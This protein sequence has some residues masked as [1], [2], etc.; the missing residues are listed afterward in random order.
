[1]LEC[2][3]FIMCVASSRGIKQQ[4]NG[5]VQFLFMQHEG[6]FLPQNDVS[7]QAKVGC[8]LGHAC[9]QGMVAEQ[10][11]DE[12]CLD[13]PRH[14]AVTRTPTA[15]LA[16]CTFESDYGMPLKCVCLPK[17]SG[18]PACNCV[19]SCEAER[20]ISSTPDRAYIGVAWYADAQWTAMRNC[21][22]GFTAL[23]SKYLLSVSLAEYK[24]TAYVVS[25]T[26]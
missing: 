20:E 17:R 26:S 1:M 24:R 4:E 8:G 3:H 10:R 6:K 16:G 2:S 12:P 18:T 5:H 21:G 25:G 13:Q 11:G 7:V 19:E 9:W 14:H 23:A 15:C 22:D